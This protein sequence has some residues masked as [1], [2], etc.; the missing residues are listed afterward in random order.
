MVREF[1]DYV[2]IGHSERREYFGETNETFNRKI[3]AA[4]AAGLVPIVCVGETRALREAGETQ[5]WVRGQVVAALQGLT[6]EQVAGLVIAY[7]PI[8]AIGTGLAATPADAEEVCGGVVRATVR[9]LYGDAVAEAIRIQYGG[10]VN[11]G[12]A[13][14]IMSQPNVDGGLVGGASL[15][16]ADFTQIVRETARAK[17]L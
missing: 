9:E 11:A 12:N 4:L 7:E 14:E 8:W 1:C 6:G 3:V 13:F 2:I 16:A 5:A 17:G 15:K 10:S